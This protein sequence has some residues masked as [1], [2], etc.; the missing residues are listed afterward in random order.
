LLKRTRSKEFAKKECTSLF[1][2][3]HQL[4]A[5][6]KANLLTFA[7]RF[8]GNKSTKRKFTSRARLCLRT[9]ASLHVPGEPR[10]QR[11]A[12]RV[13]DRLYQTHEPVMVSSILSAL[14]RHGSDIGRQGSAFQYSFNR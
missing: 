3:A 10:G 6:V 12:A 13:A 5:S 1:T 9:I 11:M 7:K 8:M 2:N 4:G 14:V